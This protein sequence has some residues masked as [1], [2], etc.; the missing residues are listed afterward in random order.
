MK[1]LITLPFTKG[2]GGIETVVSSLLNSP[3]PSKYE[4]TLLIRNAEYG[5]WLS[6]LPSNIQIETCLLGGNKGYLRVLSYIY[7]LIKT[8]NYN[9]IIDAGIKTIP[10][11][12]YFRKLLHQKFKIISWPHFSLNIYKDQV[13]HIKRADYFWA[14]STDLKK[15]L[16]NIGVPENKISLVYNPIT[17][18]N[19]PIPHSKSQ[20]VKLVYVGRL[21]EEQKNLSELFTALENLDNYQ[22]DI[23]GDGYQLEEYKQI[24]KHK[25]INAVF[26]GWSNN[27]WEEIKCADYL[28]S[29]S[30]YEGFGM[31]LAE[32]ITH[33]IPV[34]SSNCP[35]GPNDL[36]V[37]GVNGYLYELHNI[38]QLKEILA[39]CIQ[40]KY[41]WN[42]SSIASSLNK[43]S[44][45]EYINRIDK[46]LEKYNKL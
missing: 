12:Y 44:K 29:T 35:V 27:P 28:I 42:S 34:I 37:D 14:I 19:F 46:I 23:Y 32:A 31:S 38:V 33:G 40:R 18:N 5:D 36:V 26:H 39:N 7:Q 15:E 8:R 6:N 2:R 43:F 13:H 41:K 9:Y 25:N 20:Q 17:I 10:I 3:L 11:L 1:I 21:V 24:T 45:E 22:L 16:M 30:N 4:F